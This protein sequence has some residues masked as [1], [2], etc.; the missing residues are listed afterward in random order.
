MTLEIDDLPHY[1][2]RRMA[3]KKDH[4]ARIGVA[5]SALK[6]RNM[7]LLSYLFEAEMSS[8]EKEKS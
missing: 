6:S 5:L 1:L 2:S 7:V 8:A 4:P 3:Q